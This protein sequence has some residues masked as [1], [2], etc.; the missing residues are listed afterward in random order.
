[1]SIRDTYKYYLKVRNKIVYAGI[2]TNPERREKQHQREPEHANTR[3]VVVGIACTEESARLWE[4]GE[5]DRG[6]KTV[7]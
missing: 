5:R 7:H 2:T 6:I 1:M 4:R 3:L